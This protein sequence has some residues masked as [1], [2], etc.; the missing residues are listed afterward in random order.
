MVFPLLRTTLCSL[1]YCNLK[2]HKPQKIHIGCLPAL[3]LYQHHVFNVGTFTVV[4]F[5][6]QA[7]CTGALLFWPSACGTLPEFF[8]SCLWY[9]ILPLVLNFASHSFRIFLLY[10]TMGTVLG[11]HQVPGIPVEQKR[12]AYAVLSFL[13]ALFFPERGSSLRQ[14]D[15]WPLYH[16]YCLGLGIRIMDWHKFRW[17]IS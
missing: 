1:E 2:Q 9:Q 14:L 12:H 13:W 11:I 10:L 8:S 3:A 6:Q 4:T 15:E 16:K 5:V 17:W 7:V